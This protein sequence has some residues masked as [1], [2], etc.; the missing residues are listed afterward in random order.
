MLLR[1]H[2]LTL[3][4]SHAMTLQ[5]AIAFIRPGIQ[6]PSGT[7]A[8]IGAGTGLFSQALMHILKSGKVI[9]MD[10]SPH[11]LHSITPLPHIDYEILEGDFNVTLDLPSLDGILMANA[12]HYAKDHQYVLKNV[13]EGLKDNG[14]FILIEYDTDIRNEPWVP[15]PVSLKHFMDLCG[16]VGLTQPELIGERASIYQDGSM[17]AVVSR[18]LNK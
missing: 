1:S 13:L 5:E 18:K 17:Y 6:L 7:W 8:D 11:A 9:A 16:K 2:A 12:L 15:N 4:R 10:K 3:L 14:T